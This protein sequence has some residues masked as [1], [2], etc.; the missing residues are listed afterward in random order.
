MFVFQ[1]CGNHRCGP[2]GRIYAPRTNRGNYRNTRA[3][4]YLH[5]GA[6]EPLRRR[7]SLEAEASRINS[8]GAG[9]LIRRAHN[10]G[11]TR[12]DP[13]GDCATDPAVEQAC[14]GS[15]ASDQA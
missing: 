1:H 9:L 4:G 14:A 15:E 5:H 7:A 3:K 6:D 12:R 11:S 2:S 10:G 13:S 8:P